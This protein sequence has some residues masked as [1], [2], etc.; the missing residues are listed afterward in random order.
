MQSPQHVG[1]RVASHAT[2]N[3]GITL[4]SSMAITPGGHLWCT[5]YVGPTPKDD[6]NNYVVLATSGDNGK[7]WDEVLVVD[8]DGVGPVRAFDPEIWLVPDGSLCSCG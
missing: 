6:H 5:W 1:E 2:T 3:R 4:V 7:T 8:P